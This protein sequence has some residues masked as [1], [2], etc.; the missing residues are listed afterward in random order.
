MTKQKDSI[1]SKKVTCVVVVVVLWC[2]VVCCGVLW[3]MVVYGVVCR[4]GWLCV[5]VV[6]LCGCCS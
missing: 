4:C 1:Y 2:I 6:A 5:D 3:C